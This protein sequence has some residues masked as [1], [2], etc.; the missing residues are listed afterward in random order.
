MADQESDEKILNI[1]MDLLRL[2]GWWCMDSKDVLDP[3]I[4]E[5][6]KGEG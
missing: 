3:A 1:V 5:L 6:I 2:N 4:E